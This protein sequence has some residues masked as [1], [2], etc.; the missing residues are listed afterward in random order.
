MD[1]MLNDTVRPKTTAT[2]F[3]HPIIGG[4]EVATP[5]NSHTFTPTQRPQSRHHL[6]RGLLGDPCRSHASML[7]RPFDGLPRIVGK[8]VNCRCRELVVVA[9]GDCVCDI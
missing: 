3:P 9:A 2:I 1:G 6:I 8:R 7:R 5:S 4:V